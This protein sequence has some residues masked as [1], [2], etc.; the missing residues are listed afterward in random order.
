MVE[1]SS[2][3]AWFFTL[4]LALLNGVVGGG[5]VAVCY[6]R[7]PTPTYEVG[8]VL[9]L[10]L[11]A[12]AVMLAFVFLLLIFVFCSW[13]YSSKISQE[14][15]GKEGKVSLESIG[16]ITKILGQIT[17]I[18]LFISILL[19]L[20]VVGMLWWTS[21]QLGEKYQ[22]FGNCFC[23]K[24]A[25]VFSLEVKN[26]NIECPHVPGYL[27]TAVFDSVMVT[28]GSMS[29]SIKE[30]QSLS[31]GPLD[32]ACVEYLAFWNMFKVLRILLLVL[33]IVK[34]PVLL[35]N[36]S[37]RVCKDNDN[38]KQ[39]KFATDSVS[40]VGLEF[41]ISPL[42]MVDPVKFYSNICAPI[43]T[44]PPL[45][46]R[47]GPVGQEHG[48]E[49]SLTIQTSL[50]N[51][52]SKIASNGRS[53]PPYQSV[54]KL[55]LCEIEDAVFQDDSPPDP[56]KPT[57]STPKHPKMETPTFDLSKVVKPSHMDTSNTE[58]P[59]R[60][61]KLNKVGGNRMYRLSSFSTPEGAKTPSRLP[62]DCLHG[63]QSPSYHPPPPFSR[64]CTTFPKPI[65]RNSSLALQSPPLTPI[66]L[67][68]RSLPSTTVSR[69]QPYG[70][71]LLKS[72]ESPNP[73]QFSHSTSEISQKARDKAKS[74]VNW[75]KLP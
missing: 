4:V 26:L 6:K 27:C 38:Q 43:D 29:L 63:F 56:R 49:D 64:T 57:F 35:G 58:V 24:N 48:G 23:L 20:S 5:L 60:R 53:A 37:R 71:P 31:G 12:G 62:E 18:L 42:K 59:A 67:I 44:R 19:D 8:I 45:G 14:S 39:G 34:L 50:G 22:V 55:P 52:K 54:K 10:C 47:L 68:D 17:L 70:V 15:K 61:L 74:A 28:I 13:R 3:C 33:V 25:G 66:S 72:Q 65:R 69:Q 21:H 51:A 9:R 2:L 30:C 16:T 73:L 36:C 75:T 11:A 46:E 41:L 32:S 40:W 7:F 1:G